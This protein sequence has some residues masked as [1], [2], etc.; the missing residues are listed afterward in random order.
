VGQL[1]DGDDGP[2]INIDPAINTDAAANALRALIPATPVEVTKPAWQVCRISDLDPQYEGDVMPATTDMQQATVLTSEVDATVDESD[3]SK[4]LHRVVIDVDM[5]VR[6]WESSTPGHSHVFID[7]V[8]SEEVYFRLLDA[9]AEAGIVE[10]GYVRAS[11]ERRYTSVRLPWIKKESA[12]PWASQ[13]S[14]PDTTPP[15]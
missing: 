9:L 13:V 10:P 6:A 5:S 4:R 7:K 2:V 8:M 11:K 12:D 14:N 15:F 3:P 1:S